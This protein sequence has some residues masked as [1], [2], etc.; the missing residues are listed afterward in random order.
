MDNTYAT[1][2]NKEQE[3]IKVE[4]IDIVVTGTKEKPYYA[5]TNI[6]SGMAL[7]LWDMC[8]SGKNSVLN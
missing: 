7:T 2:K 8:L 1:T 5:I 3:K 4:S 6:T